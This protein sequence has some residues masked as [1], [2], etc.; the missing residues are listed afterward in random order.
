MK[1]MLPHD[2]YTMVWRF[3]QRLELVNSD[4]GLMDVVVYVGNYQLPKY[5][6]AAGGL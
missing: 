6:L 4:P 1:K 3:M 5:K 2:A